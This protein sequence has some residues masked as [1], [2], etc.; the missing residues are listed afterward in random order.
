VTADPVPIILPAMKSQYL[1]SQ[2]EE[3]TPVVVEQLE[4]NTYRVTVGEE[5]ILLD[6]H[7]VGPGLYHFLNGHNGYNL[8]VDQAAAETKVYRN[9]YSVQVKLL[10]ERQA[11]RLAAV[12]LGPRRSADGIIA[13]RAPMPGKVV[14]RLVQEGEAVVVGQ[15]II[16]IEAMKMENELR[17]V[18]EGTVKQILV[19]EG[20]NVESGENLV[21]I[22]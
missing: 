21:F 16:I 6:A 5:A 8:L 19:A 3:E 17:T 7:Q 2:N 14:K 4:G 1:V 9:G 20:A 11:A 10:D 15:G 12:D 18:V 22:E 13:I